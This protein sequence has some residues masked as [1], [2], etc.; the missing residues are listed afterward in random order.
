MDDAGLELLDANLPLLRPGNSLVFRLEKFDFSPNSLFDLFNQALSVKLS[1]RQ[2]L[3]IP[4]P[5]FGE[6]QK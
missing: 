2:F 1:S 6:Q 5:I 3:L 4:L